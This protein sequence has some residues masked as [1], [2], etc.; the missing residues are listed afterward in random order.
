M[1]M[2]LALQR[3]IQS[4][5]D[6]I[7]TTFHGRR[8]TFATFGDRVARLAAALKRIGL[9]K[10]DRIGVLGL[11]AD[12]WLEQM[13]A[14]WWAGGVLNPVNTRWSVSEMVYSLDDCDTG[15][16]LVD[17]HFLSRVE[18]IRASAQ[19]V[20]VFIHT[21]EGATPEGMLRYE[22]LIA[23]AAPVD[24]AGCAGDDLA[25]ILYTGGTTGFPKGVMHTH[26]SLWAICMQRLV[27]TP[28][29]PGPSIALHVAPLFHIGG[30]GRAL[31]QF[32]A[33]E[34]HVLVPGFDAREVLQTIEREGVTDVL[35]VPTML[36]ALITHPEFDCFRLDSLRRIIYGAS[37]IAE[38]V[39]ERAMTLWPGVAFT[40]SYGLTEAG[41]VTSNPPENHGASG[42]ASGLSR[43][44]GRAS[45]GV[46]VMVVDGEGRE[47][48]RGEVGELIVR[49]PNVMRGYWNKPEE[50][51][52]AVREAWLY[53]GDGARMDE[54]GHVFIVDRLKDMIVSGGENVYSAEVE[55]VIAR[56]P[57][58]QACA[59]IAVPHAQWGE[60]VHAVVV[61]KPGADVDDAGLHDHCRLHIAGYKCPKTIEFREALPLSAA[62]KVLKRELR[63]PHW[64]GQLRQVS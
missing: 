56:H 42:R 61:R 58:V 15:I 40:H 32:V 29:T 38:S 60:A 39:L 4:T 14:V 36:Q 57:A 62:G 18:G 63:A 49:G 43:S 48:P 64:A 1:S 51:A 27:Q 50:T 2:T 26:F 30:I 44:A 31:V 21:G 45:P 9:S 20:P 35:L 6:R 16:L 5:P 55:N 47:V 13:M 22:T 53:T 23:A 25:C 3:S 17:D 46:A 12:R 28:L 59:V 33:G 7:A 8:Q 52:R 37:P 24:D 19:R 34:S 54:D 41:G 11:N 10:G